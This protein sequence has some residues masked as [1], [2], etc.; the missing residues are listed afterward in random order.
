ERVVNKATIQNFGLKNIGFISP[1][2]KYVSAY[3]GTGVVD[4]YSQLDCQVDYYHAY[5]ASKNG[6]FELYVCDLPAD[7]SFLSEG[8]EVDLA[9]A[10]VA[11]HPGDTKVL[12]PAERL[13]CTAKLPTPR[14]STASTRLTLGAIPLGLASSWTFSLVNSGTA[15]AFFRNENSAS[16]GKM[17]KT[18]MLLGRR[19]V[20]CCRKATLTTWPTAGLLAVNG[21]SSI[22]VTCLAEEIGEFEFVF[23]VLIYGGQPISIRMSGVVVMPKLEISPQIL[24]FGGVFVGSHSDLKMRLQNATSVR[25]QVTFKLNKY[26]DFSMK[27]LEET[28]NLPNQPA[29]FAENGTKSITLAPMQTKEITTTFKPSEVAWYDFKLP[30]SINGIHVTEAKALATTETNDIGR[31]VDIR[32]LNRMPSIASSSQCILQATGLRAPIV[33]QPPGGNLQLN[34]TLGASG[35]V[36][37]EREQ[38]TG[39]N[40][41]A[42]HFYASLYL[43]L[44][45][46]I[47]PWQL[48]GVLS[49]LERC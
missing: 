32:H 35:E 19:N 49:R 28:H 10:W 45:R 41:L 25:L 43:C 21:R 40:F 15:V 14:V 29:H 42:F 18:K 6:S 44:S 7:R 11:V 23:R 47:L 24:H 4:A 37:S 36:L 8:H 17:G 46:R 30:M 3:S 2:S 16:S 27:D 39:V 31:I 34:A 13:I 5:G 22:K 12:Q 26:C 38:L 48:G 20:L 9:G 33:L 1:I